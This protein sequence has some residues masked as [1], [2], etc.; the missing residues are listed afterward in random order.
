MGLNL[1]DSVEDTGVIGVHL[2]EILIKKLIMFVESAV[3]EGE[4]V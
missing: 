4:V 3:E 2:G 1:V